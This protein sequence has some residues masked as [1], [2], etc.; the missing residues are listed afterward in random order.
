MR[1][2]SGWL[3]DPLFMDLHEQPATLPIEGDDRSFAA[4]VKKYSGDIPTQAMLDLL[5]ASATVQVTGNEVRLKNHAYIPAGDPVDKLHILGNDVGELIATIDHNLR[6]SKSDLRFQRKV[7]NDSVD[8]EA[9]NDFKQLSAKKAQ[10]L[11]EELDA[12]LSEHQTENQS[13]ARAVSMGIYY[14]DQDADQEKSS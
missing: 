11:L 5:E 9:V 6:A 4:L 1:V 3:N 8:P 7:L 13:S 12:W 2:I 10:A 14:H